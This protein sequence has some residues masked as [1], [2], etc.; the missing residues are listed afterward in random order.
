M[1]V[2]SSGGHHAVIAGTGRAGT[3]FLV[4]FLGACGL[5][6]GDAGRDDAVFERARAGREIALDAPGPIPYVVK[7]PWLF[8]YCHSLDLGSRAVDVLIVPI[9]D[10][11]EA[12]ESRIRLERMRMVGD[13]R[14]R[15]RPT[16]WAHG[17]TPGG[18]V[19]SVELGDQA[20]V[21]ARGLHELLFWAAQNGIPVLMPAF[22][23]LAHDPDYL[24]SALSP[25]L[26]EHC[27]DAT[28]REAFA[29]T[30]R[31]EAITVSRHASNPA[32]ADA[33]TAEA[34]ARA[35]AE[36]M[37]EREAER[38]ALE[39]L[40]RESTEHLTRA[41]AE[42]EE[43]R[44]RL[45]QSMDAQRRLDQVMDSHSWRLTRP[46]RALRLRRADPGADASR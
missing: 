6:V 32:T 36:L 44:A 24:I 11:H 21:L 40:V 23:R 18:A 22:P 45:E 37:E 17:Q 28:A 16:A 7:D 46:L 38:S 25:W 19:Y 8:D 35:L 20:N 42:L 5:D 15:R 43:A 3:T 34:H 30:A 26:L 14:W 9:R 29:A 12:A 33:G 1:T 13:P 2:M 41:R 39:A 31:P 27:S 10:L 4:E